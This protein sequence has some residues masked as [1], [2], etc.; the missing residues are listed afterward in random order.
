MQTAETI[1][2]VLR[3]CAT[4]GANLRERDAGFHLPLAFHNAMEMIHFLPVNVR[5]Y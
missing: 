5:V 3:A 1:I 4:R 2:A